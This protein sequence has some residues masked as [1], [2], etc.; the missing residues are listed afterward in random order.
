MSKPGS[1]AGFDRL[2]AGAAEDRAPTAIEL[3]RNPNGE[4]MSQHLPVTEYGNSCVGYADMLVIEQHGAVC[5]L[6]FAFAQ[7]ETVGSDRTVANVACRVIV[8]TAALPR[9]ARQMVRGPQLEASCD[10]VPELSAQH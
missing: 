5:H 10:D 2:A 1:P 6:L 3:S 7:R 9:M 4:P 8:P